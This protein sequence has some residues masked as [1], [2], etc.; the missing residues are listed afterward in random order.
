MKQLTTILFFILAFSI[1]AYGQ[2]QGKVKKGTIVYVQ[3][4]RLEDLYDLYL[5]KQSESGTID[6][7]RVQIISGPNRDAVYNVKK[8]LYS[9]YPDQRPYVVYQQPNFKLRVG[10]FRTRL[11]AYQLLLEIQENFPDAFIIRDNIKVSEL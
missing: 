11:E 9:N 8:D 4:E 10:S 7:Y 5:E 1:F 2:K 3:D 6:G